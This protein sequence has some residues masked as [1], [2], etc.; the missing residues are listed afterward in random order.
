MG[1]KV[2]IGCG[3]GDGMT[4]AFKGEICAKAVY[5]K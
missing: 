3:V 1:K 4:G 2:I 5:N